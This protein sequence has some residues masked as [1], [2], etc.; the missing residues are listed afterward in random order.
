MVNKIVNKY[1][2]GLS[3]LLLAASFCLSDLKACVTE[4]TPKSEQTAKLENSE[5][6]PIRIGFSS[7]GDI[8]VTLD[9][10]LESYRVFFIGENPDEGGLVI[11]YPSIEDLLIDTKRAFGEILKKEKNECSTDCSCLIKSFTFFPKAFGDYL[12][13]VKPKG[14]KE[15][16]RTINYSDGIF[17][18]K[19]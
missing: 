17:K 11:K 18:L 3:S 12:I 1:T 15:Y 19:N 8:K 2:A 6:N 13:R 14:D 7:W 10:P 4:D 16:Q 5:E 9:K